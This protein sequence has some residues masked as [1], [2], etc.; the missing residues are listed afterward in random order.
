M[1]A[2]KEQ[3]DITYWT[4][5][6]RKGDVV[7]YRGRCR[8]VRKVYRDGSSVRS[9]SFLK[10]QESSYQGLLT[11]VSAAALRCHST[12]GIEGTEANLEETYLERQAQRV[13]EGKEVRPPT[14]S[15]LSREHSKNK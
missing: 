15:D 14:Q 9:V 4:D 8:K 6:I 13:I 7:E 2:P 11:C 12:H 5:Q 10:L 3:A 1:P